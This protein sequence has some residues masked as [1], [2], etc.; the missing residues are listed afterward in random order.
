SRLG[1]ERAQRFDWSQVSEE[2]MNVYLHARGENEK[3][4]LASESRTWNR[5]FSREDE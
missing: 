4:S 3:V 5:F 1:L 2:I